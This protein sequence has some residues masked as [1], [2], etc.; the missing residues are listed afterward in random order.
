MTFSVQRNG[1]TRVPDLFAAVVI[2]LVAQGFVQRFPTTPLTPA[3]GGADQAKFKATL[4]AGPKVDPLSTEQPWR[5]QFDCMTVN[6]DQVGDVFI[7]SPLQLPNDGS[8]ATLDVGDGSTAAS[9]MFAGML[10]ATGTLPPSMTEVVDYTDARFIIRAHRVKDKATALAY[11]MTYRLTVTNRGIALY[12]WEDATDEDAVPQA[13]WFVCQRPVNHLNGETLV[14]G[15]APMFCLYGMKNRISKFVVRENDILKPSLS[16]IGDADTEDN[17]AVINSKRQVSITE[18]NRYIMSFPNGLN[19]AR[20]AYTEE[21]DM[22]AYTSADVVS[23]YSDVPISAY[24]EATP[25][26]YKAMVANGPYN[27][28]MRIL[29][30]IEG[31]PV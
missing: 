23:Q 21:L 30:L 27:T 18:N 16:S 2:D 9:K 7:S 1:F 12:I 25:R 10:N 31:G 14:A 13:S 8:V 28:G 11:P 22:I 17:A 29:M 5:I 20:Y 15:H 24:G 26:K 6:G 19:T 3:V 4:E